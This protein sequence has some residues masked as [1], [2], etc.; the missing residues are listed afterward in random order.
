[1]IYRE[2]T[3]DLDA[4]QDF[5]PTK[6]EENLLSKIDNVSLLNQM[7]N[8][9]DDYTKNVSIIKIDGSLDFNKNGGLPDK[10]KRIEK[11][12]E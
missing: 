3:I 9:N 6:S 4:S 1:M 10:S 12:K 2:T 5:D 7:G 8:H 11:L